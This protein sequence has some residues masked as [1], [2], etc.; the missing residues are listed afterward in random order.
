LK[1]V[2]MFLKGEMIDQEKL[3][4][5]L[6]VINEE[7]KPIS[8]VRASENYRRMVIGSLFQDALE[9]IYK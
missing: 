2:E 4:G 3:K 8:D 1:K 7:I 5:A 9:E 6:K